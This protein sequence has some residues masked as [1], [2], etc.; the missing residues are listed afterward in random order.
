MFPEHLFSYSCHCVLKSS[1]PL[2]LISLFVNLKSISC[3]LPNT[4]VIHGVFLSLQELLE[5]YAA[6][7]FLFI[8]TPPPRFQVVVG[9]LQ[10]P[11][12]THQYYKCHTW[13][14]DSSSHLL[15]PSSPPCP[16]LP[17][18]QFSWRLKRF[19]DSDCLMVLIFHIL[20]IYTHIHIFAFAPPLILPC[21]RAK[22]IK[23]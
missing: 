10:S 20:P 22:Q 7:P 1:R 4:N 15:S 21:S 11:F 8:S 12:M 5:V 13:H 23:V 17:C 6:A 2:Y 14:K 3:S 16:P 18:H 19:L 9:A